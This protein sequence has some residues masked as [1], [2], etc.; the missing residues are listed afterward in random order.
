M[1]EVVT[2]PTKG[3]P[4]PTPSSLLPSTLSPDILSHGWFTFM[5]IAYTQTKLTLPHKPLGARVN[6]EAD[7]QGKL[8]ERIL[9]T[10]L[11]DALARMEASQAALESRLHDALAG[12]TARVQAIE[13]RLPPL[14]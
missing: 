4:P 2:D 6:L 3:A 13:A 10:T 12:L 1:C 7:L 11:T 9:A 14:P 8:V 5:L